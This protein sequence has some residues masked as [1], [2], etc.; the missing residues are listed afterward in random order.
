MHHG[1]LTQQ[2][3]RSWS[4]PIAQLPLYTHHHG[5]FYSCCCPR[6]LCCCFRSCFCGTFNWGVACADWYKFHGLRFEIQVQLMIIWPCHFTWY[7][8]WTNQIYWEQNHSNI[9]QRLW[10]RHSIGENRLCLFFFFVL[11]QIQTLVTNALTNFPAFLTY[12][13]RAVFPAL[14]SVL[15]C[16]SPCPSFLALRSLMEP[17]LETPDLIPWDFPKSSRISLTHVGPSLSTDVLQCLPL[18]VWSPKNISTFP[19]RRTRMRILSVP[20]PLLE[21]E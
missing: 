19:V 8:T 15:R 13:N 20:S 16:Q 2:A 6:W 9:P 10:L 21:W 18:L 7:R 17:C 4:T 14:L 5:P 11:M 12:M 1:V 3:S